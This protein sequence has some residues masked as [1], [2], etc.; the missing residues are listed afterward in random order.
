MTMTLL[1]GTAVAMAM[2]ATPVTDPAI[3][4]PILDAARA[5]VS[6]RLGKPVLFKVDHLAREGDWAFLYA[7]MQDRGGTPIDLTGTPLAEAAAQG[8]ASRSCAV[9]LHR[10]DGKWQA[11]E[12]AVGPTDAAWEGWAVRHKAPPAIFRF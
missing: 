2:L 6:A 8:M 4:A 3:R 11:V 7:D 5:P 12:S 10:V 9:L 1:T